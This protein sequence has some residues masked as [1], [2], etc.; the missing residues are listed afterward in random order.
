MYPAPPVT[1]TVLCGDDAGVD[2]AKANACWSKKFDMTSRFINS[3]D[4]RRDMMVRD[5]GRWIRNS[6]LIFTFM[7]NKNK[8]PSRSY[9]SVILMAFFKF[10]QQV[11]V[12]LLIFGVG[13]G[14]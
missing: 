8:L 1:R 5:S 3:D 9:E 10:V 2:A 14:G 4:E 7:K 12:C 13:G 11:G 6:Y